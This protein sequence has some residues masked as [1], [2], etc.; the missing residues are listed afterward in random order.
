MG[1]RDEF[2][3]GVGQEGVEG[4]FCG[5]KGGGAKDGV[6]QRFEVGVGSVDCGLEK[7]FGHELNVFHAVGLEFV[8]FAIVPPVDGLHSVCKFAVNV[9]AFEEGVEF[10]PLCSV[11]ADA[12]KGVEAL[13]AVLHV[14]A[15]RLFGFCIVFSEEREVEFKAIVGDDDFGAIKLVEERVKGPRSGFCNVSPAHGLWRSAYNVV[16]GVGV[17]GGVKDLICVDFNGAG[18]RALAVVKLGEP[19]SRAR[20][21]GAIGLAVEEDDGRHSVILQE[22]EFVICGAKMKKDEGR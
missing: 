4:A 14:S 12:G 10:D 1:G 19:G 9:V 22:K 2:P 6:G 21:E 8:A 16:N 15:R 3:V 20:T 13:E 11:G 18:D 7:Q 5:N 17:F